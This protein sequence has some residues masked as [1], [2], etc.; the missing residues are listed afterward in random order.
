MIEALY[1]N[2]SFGH[3]VLETRRGC[4][5]LTH[6]QPEVGNLMCSLTG[7]TLPMALRTVGHIF[8][9]VGEAYVHGIMEGEAW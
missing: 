8:R 6:Y 3:R 2:M 1:K 4:I 9:F 7:C 5:G